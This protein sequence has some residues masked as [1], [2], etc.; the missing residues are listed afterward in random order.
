MTY[1]EYFEQF[2]QRYQP[3]KQGAWCYEDGCIYR[4]LM[5]LY[6]SSGERRW[7][8]HLVRLVSRQVGA[9]GELLGYDPREYNIDNILP[10]RVLLFL[11]EET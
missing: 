10:G 6:R 7:L 4:G 11:A 8:D 3:Y 9:D 1:P 5:L 2:C